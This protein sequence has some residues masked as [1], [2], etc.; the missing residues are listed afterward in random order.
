MRLG[1]PGDEISTS[2]YLPDRDTREYRIP[3]IHLVDFKPETP[4]T[5]P[6]EISATANPLMKKPQKPGRASVGAGTK[7]PRKKDPYYKCSGLSVHVHYAKNFKQR[8]QI[9]V[10]ATLLMENSVV[11]YGS[12]EE[13]KE[14]NWVSNAVDAS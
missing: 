6:G 14:C 10:G 7:K 4:D 1:L 2:H 13:R 5:P 3:S 11:V 8:G 9:K 12:H